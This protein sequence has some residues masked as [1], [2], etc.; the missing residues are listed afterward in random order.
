MGASGLNSH[1]SRSDAPVRKLVV[2]TV[3][4]RQQALA[5]ELRAPV[6]VSVPRSKHTRV[7]NI[8]HLFVSFEYPGR[9]VGPSLQ[10]TLTPRSDQGWIDEPPSPD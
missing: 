9:R 1:R 8:T 2:S 4:G 7:Q 10:R 6:I 5:I 3:T